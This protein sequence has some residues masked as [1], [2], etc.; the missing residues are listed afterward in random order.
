MPNEVAA[1][2]NLV[3]V[4]TCFSLSLMYLNTQGATCLCL[5]IAVC[6][7]HGSLADRAG[8]INNYLNLLITY[9]TNF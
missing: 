9:N 1:I 4:H 5:N 7:I 2:E 6:L 3:G 8:I